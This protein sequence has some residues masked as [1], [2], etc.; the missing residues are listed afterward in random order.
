MGS[1]GPQPFTISP[2]KATELPT[3]HSW[4]TYKKI[5]FN[6]LKLER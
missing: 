3:A 1:S 6:L 2:K 4:Y 5:L